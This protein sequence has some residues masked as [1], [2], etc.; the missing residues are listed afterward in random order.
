MRLHVGV[1]CRDG[2]FYETWN[3]CANTLEKNDSKWEI[4][5]LKSLNF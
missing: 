5:I 4:E 2:A 3:I 1:R